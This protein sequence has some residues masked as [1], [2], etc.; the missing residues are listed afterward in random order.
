MHNTELQH[1]SSQ[2]G[3]EMDHLYILENL[4]FIQWRITRKN[5]VFFKTSQWYNYPLKFQQ[6]DVSIHK[7]GYEFQQ[8]Y[9]Q[10]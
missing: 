10:N 7:Q 6:I 9:T 4:L 8:W 2:Y 1:V 5:N 3:V